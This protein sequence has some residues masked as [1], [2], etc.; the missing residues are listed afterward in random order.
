M[1]LM[2][3]SYVKAACAI[4]ILVLVN[5]FPTGSRSSKPAKVA[6][7]LYPQSPHNA[8][9]LCTD[10]TITVCI[11]NTDAAKDVELR[12]INL[13]QNTVVNG[14]DGLALPLRVQIG[15]N[16]NFDYSVAL[17]AL[18]DAQG[19]NIEFLV[20]N[21]E[22]EEVLCKQSL[23]IHK[24]APRMSSDQLISMAKVYGLSGNMEAFAI[25][26][27]RRYWHPELNEF[28]DAVLGYV[29]L[30]VTSQGNVLLDDNSGKMIAENLVAPWHIEAI[31]YGTARIWSGDGFK[32]IRVPTVQVVGD[33]SFDFNR[34]ELYYASWYG[35]PVWVTRQSFYWTHGEEI[36]EIPDTE[37]I[38]LWLSAENG[39][40][41]FTVSDYH[42]HAFRYDPVDS[43]TILAYFHCPL[44]SDLPQSWFNFLVAEYE[45]V[46]SM[47]NISYDHM[48]FFPDVH[49]I[50]RAVR[51][52]KIL[53]ERNFI[54]LALVG[55]P[56]L[57]P[58][59]KWVYKRKRSGGK[60]H[61][62]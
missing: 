7:A 1:V 36:G 14:R 47:S 56:Y 41:L 53:I 45:N 48:G 46:Y 38:E 50:G 17:I 16:E 9:Y 19:G 4:A 13:P 26:K 10:T 62:R 31:D 49:P 51:E 42:H 33:L 61:H 22:N 44:A 34:F 29:W 52:Y 21:A 5:I 40:E 28:D 35:S 60:R 23:L 32:D 58:K 59:I 39:E 6:L 15:E 43:Y 30:L 57:A 55:I 54:G 37:R 3:A 24:I 2:R 25:P 27:Y 8:F 20:V 18:D 11:N 12:L